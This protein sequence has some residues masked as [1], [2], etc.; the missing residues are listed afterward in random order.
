MARLTCFIEESEGSYLACLSGE[1]HA[2]FEV[3]FGGRYEN[4]PAEVVVA[5]DFIA[6]KS[7]KAHGK[8]LTTYEVKEIREL[9]PLVEEKEEEAAGEEPAAG[10]VDFEVTNP[11]MLNDD[12][13]MKLDF[14]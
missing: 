13:Q 6:E 10:D 9:E 14:E 12:S 5:E 11:E 2:R 7:Y 1:A 3:V 8:R 4:R